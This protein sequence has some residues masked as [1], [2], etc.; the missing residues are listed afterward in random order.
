[1]ALDKAIQQNVVLGNNTYNYIFDARR[2]RPCCSLFAH[3]KSLWH[4]KS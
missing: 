3:V 1:M 4:F 2:E